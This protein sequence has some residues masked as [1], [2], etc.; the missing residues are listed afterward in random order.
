[1]EAQDKKPANWNVQVGPFSL[2]DKGGIRVEQI[3][4]EGESGV[5]EDG[6]T[7]VRTT[8]LR[9]YH[10]L[11]FIL[12]NTLQCR[13]LI[14]QAKAQ[15]AKHSETKSKQKVL[16]KLNKAGLSLEDLEMLLAS[17]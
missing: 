7:K 12:N 15:E 6:Q 2:S 10:V 16:R 4:V 17:K 13:E 1:M 8:Y 3:N 9:S 14:E 5:S 11:E